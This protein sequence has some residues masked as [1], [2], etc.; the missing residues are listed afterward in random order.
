[1]FIT[2]SADLGFNYK[3][4]IDGAFTSEWYILL[5]IVWRENDADVIY[6]Y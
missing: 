3:L 2:L 5:F 4:R 6:W 1:M